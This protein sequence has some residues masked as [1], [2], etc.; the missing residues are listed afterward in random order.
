MHVL[1][2]YIFKIFET[3][4]ISDVNLQEDNGKPTKV[5]EEESKMLN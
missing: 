2:I 5:F 4:T 3:F 1:S